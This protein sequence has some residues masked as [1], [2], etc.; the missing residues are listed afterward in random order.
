MQVLG[1]LGGDYEANVQSLVQAAG[2]MLGGNA[3]IF[4]RLRSG[5]LWRRC[6]WHVPAGVEVLGRVTGSI[7]YERVMVAE[8]GPCRVIG[9]LEENPYADTDP[10]L[11]LGSFRTYV[12]QPVTRQGETVGSLAVLFEADHTPDRTELRL[13]ALLARAIEREDDRHGSHRDLEEG[14][15]KL[16][17]FFR[18]SL[19]GILIHDFRGRIREANPAAE[20]L[21]GFKRGWL[22]RMKL[23][24][25]I[26]QE[27][28]AAAR[29]SF[30]E[31]KRSGYC[32][33]ELDFRRMDGTTFP[34]EVVASR[35][36]IDGVA[37]VQGMIRD[38][39]LRRQR[40][41]EVME[42]E[43]RFRLVFEQSLDGILLH[44]K[45]GRIVEANG[46]ACRLLI[47]K[48]EALV[49]RDVLS[50]YPE[51]TR[52][53]GTTAMRDVHLHGE[54][55]FESNLVRS[56]GSTFPA[57]ISASR[58]EFKGEVLVQKILR[59]ITT[60]KEAER[61]VRRAK[62]EAER[63]NE[64]KSLFLATMSHEIRTPLNG[65]IGFSRLLE[66]GP[67]SPVQHEHL[68][69]VRHSGD[70]LLGLINDILDFSRIES[71]KLE[72]QHVVFSPGKLLTDTV[73]LHQAGAKEKY[74]TLAMA[75][76][77]EVPAQVKGDPA[78]LRQVLMNLI[79]N[80]IKFTS[81][82]VVNARLDVEDGVR[83]LFSIHDTGPG[84]STSEKERLFEPFYQ[85]DI[86]STRKHGGT[87]LGLAI[88]RQLVLAMGGKI[89]AESSEEGADFTFWIPL[90]PAD[91]P[92]QVA[93]KVMR[94][95]RSVLDETCRVLV[96][97]DQPIN[98]RLITLML[99]RLGI[100]VDLV[101][102]GPAVL[103]YLLAAD[104]LP[105]AV[106][107]DMR[108]PG[109]DGVEVA[110]RIR[111]GQAGL[112]AARLPLIAVT[113]NAMES[114]RQACFE[115]GMDHHVPKPITPDALE[116]VLLEVGLLEE[117]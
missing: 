65:I 46:A 100:E 80:G 96:A 18:S 7:C 37:H 77:P 112:E 101:V 32:R 49:G 11:R 108:M 76:A 104:P 83:L 24:G 111:S 102:D 47:A 52:E 69:M 14:E 62:E 48:K 17:A 92:K 5:K 25:L 107:L 16:G 41:A 39:S 68:S 57:E 29:T 33:A 115:A 103:D 19:D 31:L 81:E 75:I 21:F 13:L 94:A 44:D 23:P 45:E 70:I 59:D 87:G 86:S 79:G 63:A 9:N 35:F 4:S 97:E 58:L 20:R 64:A 60:R 82:G 30:R 50:L 54:A 73:A 89:K 117:Q 95:K 113:G 10:L 67:L 3:A 105:H 72:L 26:A 88:C 93:S 15:A 6:R 85:A 2:E 106:L 43:L 1:G 53:E 109:L 110:K 84:F 71:G 99:R 91:A 55:H 90:L 22:L 8:D 12:G 38:I 78:R 56:D 98:A 27:S 42:R 36:E 51:S 114:D 40:E 66:A 74:L 116:S 28:K 34:A 61:E